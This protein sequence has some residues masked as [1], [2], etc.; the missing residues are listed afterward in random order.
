M[1]LRLPLAV[2]PIFEDWV[3]RNLPDTAERMLGLVRSTRDGKMNDSQWGRRMRGE[4]PYAEQIERSFRVF[5]KKLGLDGPL[6]PLDVPGLCRHVRRAANCRCSESSASRPPHAAERA[7]AYNCLIDRSRLFFVTH[8][9]ATMPS[10]FEASEAANRRTAQ[11]LAAQMRPASL[12]EFVGQQQFLGPA[13]CF[14][15]CWPPTGWA[16]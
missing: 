13:N 6:P 3:A 12:D 15:G 4:G 16:R 8:M 9:R 1:L 10:L 5:R 7:I 14:A 2:R 11:P